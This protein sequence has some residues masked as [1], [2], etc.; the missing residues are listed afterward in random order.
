[1]SATELQNFSDMQLKSSGDGSSKLFRPFVQ[2]DKQ[3]G[4]RYFKQKTKNV[5]APE[6]IQ[7]SSAMR[8]EIDRI[9]EEEAKSDR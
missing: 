1:M 2:E 8:F 3:E 6:L 5:Y 9:D 4:H 7:L